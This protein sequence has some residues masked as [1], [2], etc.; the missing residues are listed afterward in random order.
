MNEDIVAAVASFIQDAMGQVWVAE[1][2]KARNERT[3]AEAVE[4]MLAAKCSSRS[5]TPATAQP[6][7]DHCVWL[8]VLRRMAA[9]VTPGVMADRSFVVN[10]LCGISMLT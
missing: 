10:D 6:S 9:T 8:S 7:S 5:R 1:G 3:V 2:K 4:V